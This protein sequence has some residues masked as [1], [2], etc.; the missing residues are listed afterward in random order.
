MEMY[1]LF[2]NY[3]NIWNE[4]DP[5]LREA[6]FHI[7]F[8]QIHPFEDG[9]G[10]T[11]RIILIRNLCADS[12]EPGKGSLYYYGKESDQMLQTVRFHHRHC[13]GT[14]SDLHRRRPC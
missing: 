9:N 6:M 1:Q 13:P 4:L 2:D 8:L 12:S 14:C 11:A 5:Y 7:K 3:Y 10:R